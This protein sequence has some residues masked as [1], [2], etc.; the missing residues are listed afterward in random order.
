MIVKQYYWNFRASPAAVEPNAQALNALGSDIGSQIPR[1]RTGGQKAKFSS[2]ISGKTASNTQNRPNFRNLLV[3]G[4]C[5]QACCV[6][7][8]A[9]S[10]VIQK[11]SVLTGRTFLNN[12]QVLYFW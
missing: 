1:D 7:T 9:V 4:F 5:R 12:L 2:R 11:Y 6:C 8:P 3:F 10:K